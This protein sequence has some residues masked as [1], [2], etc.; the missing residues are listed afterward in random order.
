MHT[1]TFATYS[2]GFTIIPSN[3]MNNEISI[4]RD[5]ERK[6][7]KYLY[8]FGEELDSAT[9]A[10]LSTAKTQVI[11]DSLNY[12]VV[13]NA[14]QAAHTVNIIHRDVKPANIFIQNDKGC[15]LCTKIFFVVR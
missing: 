2:W 10:A 12:S 8:K 6:F 11:N 4:Q 9:V 13:G 3:F 15:S 1:I 14:L 7:N 5:F